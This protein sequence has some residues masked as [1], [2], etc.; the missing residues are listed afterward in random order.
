MDIYVCLIDNGRIIIGFNGYFGY[1][2]VDYVVLIGMI[3]RV[4][5]DGIVKFVGVGVNFF[6]MID[7]VG[8]C[9]MI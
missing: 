1:C 7:L 4:V 3:I 8:N 2:G 5:V 9:V 6:W